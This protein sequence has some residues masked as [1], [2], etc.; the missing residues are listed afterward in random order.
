METLASALGAHV[1]RNHSNLESASVS[2][3]V[4]RGALDLRRLQ[5]VKDLIETNPGADLTIEALAKEAWPEPVPF[6]P[7]LQ[8]GDRGGA[9]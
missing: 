2:L 3:P 8:G 4:A 6:R 7:R 9:P 1:L 5:R